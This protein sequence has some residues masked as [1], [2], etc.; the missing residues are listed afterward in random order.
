MGWWIRATPTPGPTPTAYH[1]TLLADPAVSGYTTAPKVSDVLTASGDTWA[2]ANGTVTK[3]YQWY[4]GLVAIAGATSSTYTVVTADIGCKL[5]CFVTGTNGVGTWP[6][7]T[8]FTPYVRS[9]ATATYD[10]VFGTKTRSGHGGF[11]VGVGRTISSGNSSGDWTIDDLGDLCPSGTFSAQKTFSASSYLLT[12]DNAQTVQITMVANRFDVTA[13]NGSA[14]NNDRAITFGTQ[15]NYVLNN[16]GAGALVLGDDIYTRG[17]RI[18]NPLCEDVRFEPLSS[19]SGSGRIRIYGA[20]VAYVVTDFSSDFVT[21]IDFCD[22]N[23]YNNYASSA[24]TALLG[25]NNPNVGSGV[26]VFDSAFACGP[27]C[28]NPDAIYAIKTRG[29][30]DCSRNTFQNVGGGVAAAHKAGE[31]NGDYCDNIA[32]L[33]REDTIRGTYHGASQDISRNFVYNQPFYSGNHP[34]FI[35]MTGFSDSLTHAMGTLD[36]N[37]GVRN[38]GTSGQGDFQSIWIT[39]TTAPA[40]MTGTRI[41]H[42]ISMQTLAN[43]IFIERTDDPVIQFTTVLFDWSIGDIGAGTSALIAN[44]TAGTGGTI[45]QNV[46]NNNVASAFSG[47]SGATI[48][49]NTN[50]SATQVAYAAAFHAPATTGLTSR[51]AVIAAFTPKEGGT[52]R[53]TDGTYDGALLPPSTGNGTVGCWNMGEV[54]P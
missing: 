12:L 4:R 46:A 34:D 5:R 42:H 31:E 24:V 47:Q 39:N 28:A 9:A 49:T 18:L 27:S 29:A 23:F 14:S 40:K 26:G 50:L 10:I 19:Y 25:K 2:N 43:G 54:V 38:V 41:K 44:G 3:T 33:M 51:A 36:F 53:R 32:T 35:S 52:L 11:Q 48:G 17:Y 45:S 30:G 1:P 15:L 16:T 8:A 37:I 22:A 21:A 20:Y 6:G 7:Y 13:R